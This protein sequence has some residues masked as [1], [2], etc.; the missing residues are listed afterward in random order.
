VK[1]NLSDWRIITAL[2]YTQ[3]TAGDQLVS[4]MTFVS[5][6]GLVLGVAVL[7]I[8]MSVMNGFD[9]EL[10]ERVLGVLP[11]GII[12]T[13]GEFRNWRGVAKRI[14]THPEVLAAAPFS[15]GGGLL[16]AGGTIAGVSFFGIEP[17]AEAKVSII[18]NYFLTGNLSLLQPGSFQLAMGSVLAKKLSVTVGEKVTLVLPDAQLSLAGPIPRSKRFEV[19]GIFEVGSD[20]DKNQI[21]I[22]LL[23]ALALK[24]QSHV[25]AIR[26]DTADLFQAPRVLREVV[27]S[28]DRNDLFGVSWMRRHGNLYDAIQMQKSTLFLLLLMLIAVAAFNVVSNL[29]MV[30]NEKKPD[31]AILRTMGA[32]T[33]EIRSI[34]VMHGLLIGAIGISLGLL[35]GV[36][37]AN[38]ITAVYMSIE[39]FFK[40]G[41]MDEYFIHYLPAEILLSD[42]LLIGSVSLAICLVVTIYPATLAARSDPIEA[43]QYE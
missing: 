14:A 25:N 39:A 21:L 11:Q 31:I 22:N 1:F 40:L 43:L 24:R 7:V 3:S 26:I 16:V 35:L 18:G 10:K 5:I 12:F 15:E 34:F 38:Y 8:V 13:E 41:L 19:S 20:A 27:A 42:L 2:K 23:D 28:M 9:R 32:G 4:F 17:E 6:A 36:V 33:G 30:V 37:I 29:V